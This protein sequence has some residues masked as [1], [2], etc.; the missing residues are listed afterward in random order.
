[1]IILLIS[2]IL[3]APTWRLPWCGTCTI[4]SWYNTLQRISN[5]YASMASL[6]IDGYRLPIVVPPR[7]RASSIGMTAPHARLPIAQTSRTETSYS[8][9]GK[10]NQLQTENN[11]NHYLVCRKLVVHCF[12]SKQ[13]NRQDFQDECQQY[14]YNYRTLV[15]HWC[16]ENCNCLHRSYSTNLDNNGNIIV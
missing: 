16:R 12:G 6:C 2:L 10:R 3:T 1:M 4:F 13:M 15:H 11:T 9:F 7:L 14:V 8:Y 5:E